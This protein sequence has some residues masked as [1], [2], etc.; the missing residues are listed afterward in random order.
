MGDEGAEAIADVSLREHERES[1]EDILIYW[2]F[3]ALF[4]VREPAF[5]ICDSPAQPLLAI[6]DA[7]MST[8][9]G[10]ADSRGETPTTKRKNPDSLYGYSHEK[11]K[12]FKPQSDSSGDIMPKDL[13]T[14]L[15]S[16]RSCI[17][18]DAKIWVLGMHSEWL[19]ENGVSL[20]HVAP[21]PWFRALRE[22]GIEDGAI[23]AAISDEGLRSVVRRHRG[24]HRDQTAKDRLGVMS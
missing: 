14:S 20:P 16:C 19:R 10:N 3:G 21:K 22:I 8:G 2:P 15:R 24:A 23:D 7:R 11:N 6:E 5:A 12:K 9:V 18:D 13:A 17:S 4:G 1:E